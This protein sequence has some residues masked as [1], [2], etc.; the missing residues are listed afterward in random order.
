MASLQNPSSFPPPP[1]RTTSGVQAEPA[2]ATSQQRGPP[3]QSSQQPQ[4]AAAPSLPSRTAASNPPSD[5]ATP[6]PPPPPRPD[7]PQPEP[8]PSTEYGNQSQTTSPAPP[9]P[10]SRPAPPPPPRRTSSSNN[11]N[12][13]PPP[14]TPPRRQ[15]QPQQPPPVEQFSQMSVSQQETPETQSP[16]SEYEDRSRQQSTSSIDS[17]PQV[18]NFA[19]EIARLKKTETEDPAGTNVRAATPPLNK[20]K[21]P[22][23][24][25]KKKPWL[26]ATNSTNSV[27][28]TEAAPAP[29]PTPPEPPKVNM[30]TKPNVSQQSAATVSPS[31]DPVKRFDLELASL[32]FTAPL[33]SIQLPADLKGYNHTFSMSYSGDNHT[34]K[35]ALRMPENLSIVKFKL[36]WN[37]QNPLG[38]IN[39]ERTDTPPPRD[40]N[41]QELLDAHNTFGDGVASWAESKTSQM[42][43]NG[44]CW[45]LAQQAIDQ[46]SGGYA[47]SPQ[48][49]THGYLIYQVTPQGVLVSKDEIKRG[50]V[51]QYY[52]AKFQHSNGSTSFAGMP[53]HTAVVTNVNGSEIEYLNQNTGGVK[54]VQPGKQIFSDLVSGDVKIFRVVWKEWAGELKA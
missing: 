11:N 9:Q 40:L 30:A 33:N 2:P 34:L 48:G 3:P 51:I 23:P 22:P 37:S 54:R 52:Q 39:V 42:V 14:P 21:A 20:K 10:G 41:S 26:Q 12:A 31:T 16:P 19:A 15:P 7:L 35:I 47:L 27:S 1:K 17:Q 18:P 28:S 8:V 44:E 36:T 38:T 29:A 50:D 24:P 13:T 32:W 4:P 46:S 25:P 45:T 49:L 6:P 43:G 53:D 5:T